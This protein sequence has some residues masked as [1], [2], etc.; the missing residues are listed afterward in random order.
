MQPSFLLGMS[1]PWRLQSVFA[2]NHHR[3]QCTPSRAERLSLSSI[4]EV[5]CGWI[6]T[7]HKMSS[8]YGWHAWPRVTADFYNSMNLHEAL[9]R[10]VLCPGVDPL[11]LR[12]T[13]CLLVFLGKRIFLARPNILVNRSDEVPC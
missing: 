4:V 6:R 2:V 8:R 12:S 9:A 11:L 10:V 7:E 3:D 13:S 5:V 1:P